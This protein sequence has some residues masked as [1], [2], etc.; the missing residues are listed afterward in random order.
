MI[1]IFGIH[2]SQL[3]DRRQIISRLDDRLY[4]PWREVHKHIR[5][6]RAAKASLAGALLLQLY[7]P[8]GK[9]AYDEAGRPYL[10]GYDLDLSITHTEQSVFCA[11]ERR[12]AVAAEQT[13]LLAL[14]KSLPYPKQSVSP[15]ERKSLFMGKPR[16]GVDAEEISRISHVRICP[17]ANRWFSRCEYDFFQTAPTDLTFLRVWTRKEAL[18]KW[19]GEG[20]RALRAADTVTAEDRYGVRFSEYMVDDIVVTLCCHADSQPPKQIQM[21]SNSQLLDMGFSLS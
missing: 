18:I 7:A 12:H 8:V 5:D 3:P 10:E 19:T 4:I 15:S 17:M 14:A 2:L 9:L 21:V 20:L 16:V 13:N 1:E 6:D 11:L